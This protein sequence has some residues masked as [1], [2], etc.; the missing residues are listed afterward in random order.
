MGRE[1]FRLFSE[2]I[3]DDIVERGGGEGEEEEDEEENED[4]EEEEEEDEESVGGLGEV[5]DMS[6]FIEG[7][8][9]GEGDIV[10]ERSGSGDCVVVFESGEGYGGGDALEEGV[11]RGTVGRSGGGGVAI[12]NIGG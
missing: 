10:G 11:G 6:G 1:V 9:D 12:V 2:E 4:E 3:I 7:M 8:G 5:V